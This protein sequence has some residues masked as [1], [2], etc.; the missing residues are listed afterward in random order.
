M[1]AVLRTNFISYSLCVAAFSIPRFFLSGKLLHTKNRPLPCSRHTEVWWQFRYFFCFRGRP[2][3]AIG[4]NGLMPCAQ[5]AVEAGGQA[6]AH[7]GQRPPP[8]DHERGPCPRHWCCHIG[9]RN[10]PRPAQHHTGNLYAGLPQTAEQWIVQKTK[11]R[12]HTILRKQ[13]VCVLLLVGREGFEP[14]LKRLWESRKS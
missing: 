2:L 11:N 14:P 6:P 4:T 7:R 12:S 13:R 8:N 10:G 5:S 9:R 3:P 1:N